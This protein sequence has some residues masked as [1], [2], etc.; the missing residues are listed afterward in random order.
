MSKSL[1]AGIDVLN[2]NSIRK[3]FGS[4]GVDISIFLHVNDPSDP[5]N[6]NIVLSIGDA[7]ISRPTQ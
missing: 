1:G 5:N 4:G 2:S 6:A 7:V 3:L